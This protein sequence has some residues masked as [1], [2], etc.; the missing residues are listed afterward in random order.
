MERTIGALRVASGAQRVFSC[1]THHASLR[2]ERLMETALLIME[3]GDSIHNLCCF[4]RLCPLIQ[5]RV[6]VW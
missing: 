6:R 1:E 2:L 4:F 5:R 3:V